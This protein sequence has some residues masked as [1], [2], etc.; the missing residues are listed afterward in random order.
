M[1]KKVENFL[2]EDLSY[3]IRGCAFRVYN[4]LGFGHKENV[5]QEALASE[6]EKEKINFERE[7]ILPVIYEGRKIGNYKP[8]FVVEDK[9]IIEIKAVPFMPPNYEKQL[10]HYLKST[11]YKLGLLINFGD[12]HLDIKRRIWTSHYQR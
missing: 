3:K 1:K 10:T 2:Y 7:K 5:Y 11:N 4:T 9:I 12:R 6:F 8:D